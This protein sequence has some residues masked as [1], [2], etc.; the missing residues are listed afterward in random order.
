M[1][2]STRFKILN[3]ISAGWLRVGVGNAR[4][5]SHMVRL[6]LEAV[7]RYPEDVTQEQYRQWVSQALRHL[8]S[9]DR[10]L[11]VMHGESEE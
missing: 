9:L 8:D 7:N 1:K 2:V 5:K 6:C 11:R 3:L 4:Y 10:A